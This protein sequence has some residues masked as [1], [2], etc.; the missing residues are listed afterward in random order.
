MP[1]IAGDSGSDRHG[2]APRGPGLRRA[3]R[4]ATSAGSPRSAGR[5]ARAAGGPCAA[6]PTTTQ[7]NL[8][9]ID[10]LAARRVSSVLRGHRRDSGRRSSPNNRRG[11]GRGRCERSAPSTA[12]E[13][14]NWPASWRVLPL[15]TR[16]SS[17]GGHALG[18]RGSRVTCSI[19]AAIDRAGLVG[20]DRRVDDVGDLVLAQLDAAARRR[21]TSPR[22]R[23]GPC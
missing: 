23:A 5:A 16:C 8:L 7:T 20:L 21:R 2:P 10:H 15:I 1:A 12:C 14:S 6:S 9:G 17:L 13:V 4:L 19:S 11:G 18:R 3:R 22:S